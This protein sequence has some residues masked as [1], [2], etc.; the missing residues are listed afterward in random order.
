MISEFEVAS[1]IIT[2][3]QVNK[4]KGDDKIVTDIRFTFVDAD[5]EFDFFK[6]LVICEILSQPKFSM[7]W[8]MFKDPKEMYLRAKSWKEEELIKST[9][10]SQAPLLFY[11]FYEWIAND[12]AKTVY[13]IDVSFKT[14]QNYSQH[15]KQLVEQTKDFKME[16]FSKSRKNNV[17]N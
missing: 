9:T 8:L 12:I 16:K 17:G 14:L 15:P 6:L 13:N 4:A 2:T 10:S 7:R 11:Q 3:N 1:S 5:K